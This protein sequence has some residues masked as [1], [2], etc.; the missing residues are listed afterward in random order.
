MIEQGGKWSVAM[1]GIA[2]GYSLAAKTAAVLYAPS[3]DEAVDV[4]RGVPVSNMAENLAAQHCRSAEAR[5]VVSCQPRPPKGGGDARS[6]RPPWLLYRVQCVRSRLRITRW[7]I[8]L[9]FGRMSIKHPSI[10]D[11]AQS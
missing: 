2:Q 8:L 6:P 3:L 7:Q 11:S 1:V 9:G 10:T 4:R 5:R